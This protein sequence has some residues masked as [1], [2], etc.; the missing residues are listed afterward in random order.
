MT[1][2]EVLKACVGVLEKITSTFVDALTPPASYVK[3]NLFFVGVSF[4]AVIACG[5]VFGALYFHFFEGIDI[6]KLVVVNSATASYWGQLGDF[7]GGFLNPLLSFL[8]LMAVL[9]TMSLQR[10]EMKAAQLEAKTA[11]Q[12]QRQQTAVYSKQMFEST[13][14]GMLDVHAKILGDIKSVGLQ[15]KI[16]EG[17]DAIDMF[18][19]KFKHSNSYRAGSLNPALATDESIRS[20]IK[21]FCSN[22]VSV[23]GHYFRNLYWIMKMIDTSQDVQSDVRDDSFTSGKRKFYMDYLRKRNYTNIVRA[24]LSE[25]EMAMLQ[26]N[27]LGPYGEDLKYYVEKYSLLK[28]LGKSYFGSWA[29]YM[30]Q[31]FNGMAFLGLEHID[32]DELMKMRVDRVNRNT[33][34]I[35]K[36][37]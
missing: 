32:V 26:I 4:L 10:A 15:G 22:N 36:K 21:Q 12:E 17:R 28:P 6:P 31:K 9:K 24:Q 1:F 23:V 34:A 27:C 20:E 29:S 3:K 18:V 33:S 5:S 7:A 13:L 30:S 2:K 11:T 14:F 16:S 25:S 37:S 35:R 19:K 8:A